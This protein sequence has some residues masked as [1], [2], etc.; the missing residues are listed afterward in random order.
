MCQQTHRLPKQ[1]SWER[2]QAKRVA[3]VVNIN[4]NRLEIPEYVGY[5]KS[6]RHMFDD[7]VA[8]NNLT[9]HFRSNNNKLYNSSMT[10]TGNSGFIPFH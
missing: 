4:N 9:F 7:K 5:S 6:V 1:K 3:D 8:N 10:R 2:D